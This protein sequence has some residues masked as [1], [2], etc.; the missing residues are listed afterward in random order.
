MEMDLF[1]N[2]MIVLLLSLLLVLMVYMLAVL[3][4]MNKALERIVPKRKK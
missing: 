2:M 3:V 1:V 4:K